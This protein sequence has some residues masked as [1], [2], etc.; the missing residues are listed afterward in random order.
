MSE[1]EPIPEQPEDVRGRP[2]AI[3]IGI[4]IAGILGGALAVFLL[5]GLAPAGGG[6]TNPVSRALVPP[7]TAFDLRTPIERARQDQIDRLD[8]WT[9]ADAQHTRVKLPVS[10][11]I[12]NY[13]R[14]AK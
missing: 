5:M 8:A 12:E 11:A 7:A 6:R 10:I 1:F 9:W 14:G 3:T 4:T 13:L 2:V